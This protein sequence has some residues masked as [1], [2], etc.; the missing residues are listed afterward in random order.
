MTLPPL[1]KRQGRYRR[2]IWLVGV[3]LPVVLLLAAGIGAYWIPPL[4]VPRVLS[5]KLEGYAVLVE[6]RFPRVLLAALVGAT[7][8]LSGAVL[9]GMFRNPL[10]DPGLI[11]VSAGAGFGAALW[12]V[13]FG[14][15][16]WSYLGL[17]LAAFLGG[18]FTVVL[19]WRVAQSSPRVHTATLLLA[20]I[21]L[22]SV[23]GAAIGLLLFLADDQQLRS[24]TFW[25]L[26]GFGGA[27]WSL[28]A[29]TAPFMLVAIFG[30]LRLAKPL[31]ALV[32]G[33][34][35]AYHLGVSVEQMKRQAIALTALGVGA[36]VAAAGGIGFVGLV[37]PHLFRLFAGPDHRY[38][39]VGSALGG[40]VLS[41]LADLISRTVVAP[42]E[43]PVG[44]ITALVGGP[45]FLWL[46]LRYKKETYA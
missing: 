19:V 45:F 44:V 14:A 28:L 41:V 20:G 30:L 13:L 29:L 42:A 37:V 25:T 21:A 34:G 33:E 43:L 7:L 40:A 5:Q 1:Q 23:S 32:L 35:E 3:A 8:A 46:L 16:G 12:I 31:N 39:L 11:G 22:N 24:I 27:N 9:Q 10:A 6:I 18:L 38:L 36:A 15:L 26:G 4:E 17:P 2:A